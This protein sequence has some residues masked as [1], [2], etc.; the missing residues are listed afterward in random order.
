MNTHGIPAAP[1]QLQAAAEERLKA[2]AFPLTGRIAKTELV[3]LWMTGKDLCS[4]PVRPDGSLDKI[5]EIGD[6]I[7]LQE[8]WVQRQFGEFSEAEYYSKCD[9]LP[10]FI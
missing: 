1:W 9:I 2:I 5:I 3:Y 4:S 6:R 7:Y 10:T 8:E